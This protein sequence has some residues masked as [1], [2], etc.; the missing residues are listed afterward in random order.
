[1]SRF[2]MASRLDS[3]LFSE[4]ALRRPSLF[5]SSRGSEVHLNHRS[6]IIGENDRRTPNVDLA[7]KGGP[8]VNIYFQCRTHVLKCLARK[9]RESGSNNWRPQRAGGI[10]DHVASG[11]LHSLNY[12]PPGRQPAAAADFD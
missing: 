10:S 12:G 1:M 8:A 7:T 3:Q 9:D 11:R 4:N 5:Q 2:S 6:C